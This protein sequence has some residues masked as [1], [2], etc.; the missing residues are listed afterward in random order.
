[1]GDILLFAYVV[2]GGI[3]AGWF[4]VDFLRTMEEGE[5]SGA[6]IIAL[7]A[8]MLWPMFAG[9]MIAKA[10]FDRRANLADANS[11]LVEREGAK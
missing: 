7:F 9:G 4:L 11:N 5:R 1:M 6:L 2:I 8:W 3:V 10:Y